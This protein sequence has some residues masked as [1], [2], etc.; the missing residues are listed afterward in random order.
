MASV[1][2]NKDSCLGVSNVT[3]IGIGYN[4]NTSCM[5]SYWGV[6]TK[7]AENFSFAGVLTFVIVL[8]L[9]TVEK[10]QGLALPGYATNKMAAIE[11]Q[12]KAHRKNAWAA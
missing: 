3:C 1:S 2:Q 6:Q 8:L 4:I 7:P 10:G 5:Y 11:A 12:W 9:L